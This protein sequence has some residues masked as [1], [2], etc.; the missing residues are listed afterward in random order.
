M[1][2]KFGITILVATGTLFLHGAALGQNTAIP[3]PPALTQIFSHE[4]S[5]PMP[6]KGPRKQIALL[7]AWDEKER[8]LTVTL[9]NNS[10]AA[11]QVISVQT[12]T[13]LYVNRI[14]DAIPARGTAS[15]QLTYVTPQSERGVET[16]RVRTSAG[17][18]NFLFMRHREAVV[19][20]EKSLRWEVG[21]TPTAK[22]LKFS[23][24][25]KAASS[26]RAVSA[27][28][29]I[30]G[31]ST[32]ITPGTNGEYT[33]DITPSST[34]NPV[35][36]PVILEFD[37]AMPGAPVLIDAAIVRPGTP[38]GAKVAPFPGQ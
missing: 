16:V 17:E 18:Q 22:R 5:V 27:R 15:L 24:D 3:A 26:I 8:P 9:D 13:G 11:V 6:M 20:V 33:L 19:A 32:R 35:K 36:I 4:T 28:I 34:A 30:P 25:K 14:P 31:F 1:K 38:P 2:T 23:V 29:P 21:E 10:N 7:L 12:S 37:P